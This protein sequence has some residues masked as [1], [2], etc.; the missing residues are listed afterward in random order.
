MGMVESR[1]VRRTSLVIGIILSVAGCG[2]WSAQGK[3][4]ISTEIGAVDGLQALEHR[5]VVVVWGQNAWLSVVGADV[6]PFVLYEDGLLIALDEHGRW[7]SQQMST[8]EVRQL[9]DEIVDGG[10]ADL[11]A[12]ASTT[13]GTDASS[14][15]I[16]VRRH[17]RWMVASVYGMDSSCE[18]GKGLFEKPPPPGFEATCRRLR[19]LASGTPDDWEPQEVELMISESPWSPA[20]HWPAVVPPPDPE[21]VAASRCVYRQTVTATQAAAFR[22][23]GDAYLIGAR[24]FIVRGRVKVPADAYLHEVLYAATDRRQRLWRR[25]GDR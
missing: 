20:W 25:L 24:R 22:K 14:I 17:D 2:G 16:L 23:L 3:G 13:A 11:P 15:H 7:R 6:P 18:W 19:A 1:A 4:A 5:P 21:A 10:F 9:V 12:S 8:W